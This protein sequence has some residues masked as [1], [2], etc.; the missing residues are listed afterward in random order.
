MTIE[1]R[2]RRDPTWIILFA[3]IEKMHGGGGMYAGLIGLVNASP[4]NLSIRRRRV[5]GLR[6]RACEGGGM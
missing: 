2:A 4:A 3:I 1:L 5:W 6:R